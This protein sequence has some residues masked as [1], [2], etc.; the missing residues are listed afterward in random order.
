MVLVGLC[1]VCNRKGTNFSAIHNI[2]LR[3]VFIVFVVYATAKVLIF[4]QFTTD[5]TKAATAVMLCMQPQRY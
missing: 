2:S 4:Q 3:V 1:C 5:S